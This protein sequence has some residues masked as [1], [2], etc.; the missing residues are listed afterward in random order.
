MKKILFISLIV[1]F[2]GLICCNDFL[3]ENPKSQISTLE[4]FKSAED[5]YSA[6]NILYRKG[7]PAFYYTA[8]NGAARVMDG[9]FRAG[10]FDNQYKG[11]YL[12]RLQN[13]QTDPSLDN[14]SLQSVWV[15][16]Y[17]VIVRN[18]NFAIRNIPDCPGLTDT[19]RDQLLAEAKF[20]RALNY[21]YL[22]KMFGAVPL[23][24]DYYES[25][26]N[27]YI[28]R[29]SENKI[30][31]LIISDL[32]EALENGKLVDAPMPANGF[33]VSR[34]SVSALLADVYLNMAGY[35]V[36]DQTKYVEAANMAV[37]LINNPNYELIQNGNLTDKSA[38]NI[39]KTSD[40]EKEYLYT[41]EYD[42]TI[43]P[44]GGYPMFC[45]P[46]EAASWG[47]FP[48]YN[49]CNLGYNPIAMLHTLYDENYDL[50]YQEKQYFHSFYTQVN[51]Q[52]AGT[53]RN[54]NTPIPF[55]WWE[56][57]AALRTGVSTKD[58]VHYRL[59]E[60]Y[61][62]AAEAIVK[63]G[64][65]VTDEAAGF[66]ATIQSRASLNKTYDEIK[67]ELLLLTAD[68][69]IKEVWKEKIRELMFECKIW[70]DITRTRMYPT[71]DVS[72]NFDFI[73]LIGATNYFGGVYKEDNLYFP[74]AILEQ[75]RNPALL[76]PPLK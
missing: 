36:N 43:S 42:A 53:V 45:F 19:E 47:E 26:D 8:L 38:Y 39:L 69:F 49:I 30:Y 12:V 28:P 3:E 41:V 48:R 40:N 60:M 58:K 23:I 56:E 62:I 70:N 71:V 34:G 65:G 16:C 13:S 32:R 68:E 10:L 67:S 74:I 35:P 9:G 33:R 57:E 24:T 15:S 22:V 7:F 21:F 50:R 55:F 25:L 2:W 75:Q 64:D 11:E 52:Y 66:L 61:F 37:S 1:S 63:S 44:G 27:M 29:S 5:A 4:F 59:T 46:Q 6:V 18:A 72:N 14:S 76:E 73:N 51:G 31:S 54:F 20:F 17:E